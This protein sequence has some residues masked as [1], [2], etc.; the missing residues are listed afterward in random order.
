VVDIK[1]A[2][3][4]LPHCGRFGDFFDQC[5]KLLSDDLKR[6]V[7]NGDDHEGDASIVVEAFKLVS[8]PLMST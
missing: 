6:N 1:H 2:T 5:A 7:V 3:V 8:N 4:I